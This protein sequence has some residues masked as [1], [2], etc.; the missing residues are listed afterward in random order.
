[1]RWP[2]SPASSESRVEQADRRRSFGSGDPLKSAP[3]SDPSAPGSAPDGDRRPVWLLDVDGVLNAHHPGWEGRPAE[4]Y[5]RAGGARFWIRWSPELV[6]RLQQIDAT[7]AVEIRWATTWVPWIES[8]EDLLGL[9]SW[10]AAWA[11][12]YEGD[13]SPAIPTPIR[14]LSTAL[15]IVERERR[16]LIW[17]D[18]DAIPTRGPEHDRIAGA[19]VPCLLVRPNSRMGLQ[20]ADLDAIEQFLQHQGPARA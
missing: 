5:A 20:P 8:I 1:M 14:K 16:A 3:Q 2:W 7:G 17:T 6:A 4:G 18:D 15:H 12:P 9:P 19:G 10:T 11:G 13:G